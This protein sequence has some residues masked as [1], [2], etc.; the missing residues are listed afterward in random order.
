MSEV[1]WGKLARWQD[2]LARTEDM[3]QKERQHNQ[4]LLYK[5]LISNLRNDL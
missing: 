1:E 5:Y 4:R 3:R 2:E